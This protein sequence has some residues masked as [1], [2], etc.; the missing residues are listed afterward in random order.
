MGRP[1]RNEEET[2]RTTIFISTK[3]RSGL[4]KAA[5]VK[6]RSLTG[7]VTWILQRYM[8]DFKEYEDHITS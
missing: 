4:K 1:P 2:V 3:L 5:K 8:E 7:Q 6:C